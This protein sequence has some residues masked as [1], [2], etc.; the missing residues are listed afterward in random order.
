[1]TGERRTGMD[2]WGR[3]LVR[4][5]VILLVLT[6]LSVGAALTGGPAGHTGVAAVVVALV[7]SF[8]KARQ[9]LDHFLDLRRAGQGWQAVFMALLLTILGSCL[10]I[11]AI[12]A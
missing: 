5:W 3:R 8:V 10:V 11:Y 9:V 7:A 1:M 4:A 6:C 12:S 2:D